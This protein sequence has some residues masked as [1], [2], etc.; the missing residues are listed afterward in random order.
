MR[1]G[2]NGTVMENWD[3]WELLSYDEL[4]LYFDMKS[5]TDRRLFDQVRDRNAYN[6]HFGTV[7]PRSAKRIAP[8]CEKCG[9]RPVRLSVKGWI[10]GCYCPL[11]GKRVPDFPEELLK[12]G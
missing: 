3:R 1:V 10:Y 6:Y 8:A 9:F 5:K 4:E 2:D 12:E 7:I 11:C